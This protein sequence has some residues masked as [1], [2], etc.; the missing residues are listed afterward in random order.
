MLFGVVTHRVT[1]ALLP[2]S[3][4][5]IFPR[6]SAS[7]LPFVRN[8]HRVNLCFVHAGAFS[9]FLSRTPGRHEQLMPPVCPSI[10]RGPRGVGVSIHTLFFYVL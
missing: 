1:S 8:T 3:V 7:P 2:E 6:A 5:H 9:P 10:F 4:P